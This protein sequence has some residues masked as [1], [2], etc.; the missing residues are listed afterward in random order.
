MWTRSESGASIGENCSP[1]GADRGFAQT[2]HRRPARAVTND[3]ATVSE[4]IVGE[5]GLWSAPEDLIGA[6]L[7]R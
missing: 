2:A 1:E 7:C 3:V 4:H 5:R 6:E